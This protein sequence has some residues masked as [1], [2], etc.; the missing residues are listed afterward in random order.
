M[1]GQFPTH[2]VRACTPH[3][4][5][6]AA[7]P[8]KAFWLTKANDVFDWLSWA[9][10]SDASSDEEEDMLVAAAVET[11]AKVTTLTGE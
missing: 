9:F 4:T 8:D 11:I 3:H 10:E 2:C 1:L 6:P 5:T 7:T